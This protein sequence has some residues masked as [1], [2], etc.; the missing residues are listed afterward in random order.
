MLSEFMSAARFIQEM[1]GL[2]HLVKELGQ[3]IKLPIQLRMDNQAA[4]ASITNEAS[5]SKAKRQIIQVY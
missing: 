5:S 2:Y 1:M 4:I 3:P